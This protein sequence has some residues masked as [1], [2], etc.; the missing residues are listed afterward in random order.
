MC[1]GPEF[2]VIKSLQRRIA[3]IVYEDGLQTRDF[4]SV[5]DVVQANILEM[6]KRNVDYNVFNVGTGIP[7]SIR[8]VAQTL[9]GLYGK[10]IKPDITRKFS[11]DDTWNCVA[12]ISKIKRIGHKP[13]VSFEKG[14]GELSQWSRKEKA[15]DK[16]DSANEELRKRGLS[17]I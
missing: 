9:F 17:K 7:T 6:E 16:F 1:T 10:S 13:A 3:S 11:K 2:V 4:V 15:V 14:M 12:D 8:K 5:H